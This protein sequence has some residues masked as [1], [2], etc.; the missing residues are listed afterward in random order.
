MKKRECPRCKEMVGA[1]DYHFNKHIKKCDGSGTKRSKLLPKGAPRICKYCGEEIE[2]S[3]AGSHAL[4]CEMNPAYEK[5]KEILDKARKEHF[6]GRKHTDETKKKLSKI[7][8]KYLEENPDKVPYLL[9]HYSK[10]E[11]YPEKYFRKIFEKYKVD[12]EQEYRVK[13]YSLDFAIL[14]K[15][16]DIEIDGE[17][18]YL[19]PTVIKS[20]I[21]RNRY[22]SENGWEVIRIRWSDY[23]K[24]RKEERKEFI[25]NL[26][27]LI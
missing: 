6:I 17:Q 20:D 14:S 10:G 9:N 3:K 8:R 18:H 22:L 2:A 24:L 1:S 23:Q 12:F 27:K 13:T 16:I 4:H 5:N 21:R 11:S 7:R 26:L 25:N 19:D 15:K